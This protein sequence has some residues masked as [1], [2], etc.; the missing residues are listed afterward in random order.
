MPGTDPVAVQT[1]QRGDHSGVPAASRDASRPEPAF[2]GYELP[3]PLEAKVD[4]EESCTVAP[5]QR[6]ET[7][8]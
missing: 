3:L 1:V 5:R 2:N 4:T 7:H 8:E 6:K